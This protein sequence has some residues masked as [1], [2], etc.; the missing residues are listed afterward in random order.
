MLHIFLLSMSSL[1][2]TQPLIFSLSNAFKYVFVTAA[3]LHQPLAIFSL[4]KVFFGET[5]KYMKNQT[6]GQLT[7]SFLSI[8]LYA[9]GQHSK[10]RKS[11]LTPRDLGMPY[12]DCNQC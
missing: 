3:G 11:Y 8:P 5:L 4:N 6:P 12:L 2:S 9:I 1:V 7:E 10:A